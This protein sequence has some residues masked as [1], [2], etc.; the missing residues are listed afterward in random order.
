MIRA[1]DREL[2]TPLSSDNQMIINTRKPLDDI[3]F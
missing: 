2:P 3:N 1:R